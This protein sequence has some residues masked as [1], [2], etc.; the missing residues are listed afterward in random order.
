MNVPKHLCPRCE[1]FVKW[2]LLFCF[3]CNQ[4]LPVDGCVQINGQ[5]QYPTVDDL[6]VRN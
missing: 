6:I 2:A 5:P 1:R 4:L 3:D